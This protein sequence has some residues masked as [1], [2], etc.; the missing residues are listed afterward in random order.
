MQCLFKSFGIWL[1]QIVG[2]PMGSPLSPVLVAICCCA[3]AE[4]HF[5]A[6]I[7]DSLYFR[8]FR[9]Y[10]FMR[11]VDDLFGIIAYDARSVTSLTRARLILSLLINTAYDPN[12]ILKAEPVDGWFPLLSSLVR[13][14]STGPLDVRFH[15]KNWPSLVATSDLAFLTLQHRSSFMSRQDARARILGALHRLH[16][17]VSSHTYRLVGVIEM[18]CE[19]RAHGYSAYCFCQALRR[20]A[21]T[22]AMPIYARMCPIVMCLR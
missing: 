2:I 13:F 15:N 3:H 21:E 7:R 12:L 9:S 17:T 22:L 18:F 10:F 20:I 14:P 16:C 1:R 19:F 11:Y 4:H 8:G 5:N 6:S